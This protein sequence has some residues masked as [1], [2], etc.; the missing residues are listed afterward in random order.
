MARC[1]MY[2]I[3]G[4]PYTLDHCREGG[5]LRMCQ[6][7]DSSTHSFRVDGKRIRPFTCEAH[8]Q[9]MT[10]EWVFTNYPDL[11]NHT[12]DRWTPRVWVCETHCNPAAFR[13][14]QEAE[15]EQEKIEEIRKQVEER[16]ERWRAENRCIYCGEPLSW[17]HLFWKRDRH[18]GCP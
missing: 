6:V 5:E 2:D 16:H 9:W 3:K 13:R 15:K 18:W 8:G 1:H 11:D 14:M 12:I 10:G 7:C 4:Y 17:W